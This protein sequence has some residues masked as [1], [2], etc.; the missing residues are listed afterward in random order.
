MPQVRLKVGRKY[1]DRK[2]REY[3]V[4]SFD[5]T[6]PEYRYWAYC[7]TCREAGMRDYTFDGRHWLG[8]EMEFDLIKEVE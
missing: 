8:G 1:L 2:G 6:D 5:H 4:E 7:K 3:V